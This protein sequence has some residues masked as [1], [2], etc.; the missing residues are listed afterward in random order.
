MGVGPIP[1]FQIKRYG[2]DAGLDSATMDL[3]EYIIRRMD[4]AYMKW[5]SE[6]AKLNRED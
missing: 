6:Q 2:S 5:S 4:S 1:H 3:F